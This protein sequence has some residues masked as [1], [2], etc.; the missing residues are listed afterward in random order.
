MD[1]LFGYESTRLTVEEM[2]KRASWA[3]LH[4]ELR[5]RLVAMF[6]DAQKNL[7]DVGFGGGWRSSAAQTELFLSRHEE[8]RFGSIKWNGKRWKLKRGA[9]PAAPPNSSYHEST[10]A[11]GFAFAA[12]LVGDLEWMNANCHKFGLVHFKNVN[13]EPWHVQFEEVPRSRSRYKGQQPVWW[14]LPTDEQ[15]MIDMIVLDYMKGTSQW[16]AFLW[17]GETIQWIVNG[18]AYGVLEKTGVKRVDV[19]KDELLGVIASSRTEGNLPSTA[20][21]AV[22]SAWV[23]RRK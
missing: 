20:D 1:F 8:N 2:E 9:A 18:H 4:P 19:N 11:A 16:I 13:N 21:K 7:T 10:D 15:E 17:T 12:D 5:R 6:V 3:R 22:S 23:A 14:N